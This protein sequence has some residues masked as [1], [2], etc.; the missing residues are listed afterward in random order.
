[1]HRKVSVLIPAYNAA[2][3]I[4]AAVGTCLAQDL[5]GIEIVL[6][7]DASTDGTADIA[8]R[9][10]AEISCVRSFVL[11]ANRGPGVARQYAL[12]R[13]TGEWIALLDVDDGWK[14]DRLRRLLSAAEAGHLDAI[15]D[16]L[17]L[18]DPGDGRIVRKAFPIGDDESID[19][20]ASRFLRNSVP[21]GYVTMGWMK[22]LVRRDFLARNGI[23]WPDLR[24]AEDF[25]LAI[26]LLAAEPRFRLVGWAGYLYTQRRGS[27]TG[28]ASGM[29]RTKRSVDAQLA[30]IDLAWDAIARQ[31]PDPSALERLRK[32]RSEVRATSAVL[33][34]R[35]A[36]SAGRKLAAAGDLLRSAGTPFALTRC[37]VARYGPRAR[38]IR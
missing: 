30:A 8:A 15:A 37:V 3:T 34:A 35:D 23:A 25:V 17:D 13:A 29:S 11:P 24:H 21:G 18:V 16:N 6:V 14:P 28:T 26:R 36:W 10:A 7:D 31:A 19:L 9:L 33:D 4:E 22:P 12:E 1:M 27:A 32:M 5:D 38:R 2:A 20:N